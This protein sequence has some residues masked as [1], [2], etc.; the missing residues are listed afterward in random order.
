MGNPYDRDRGHARRDQ[1]RGA[2]F[3]QQGQQVNG[4][5]YNADQINIG[6]SI[7]PDDIAEG[8]KRD[9]ERTLREGE[10]A[11]QIQRER[12]AQ[13]QREQDQR[14]QEERDLKLYGYRHYTRD[15]NRWLQSL[16]PRERWNERRRQSAQTK[17]GKMPWHHHQRILRAGKLPP[18]TSP[19]DPRYVQAKR[20]V[21]CKGDKRE[22]N[23]AIASLVVMLALILIAV[24]DNAIWLAVILGSLMIIGLVSGYRK[25]RASP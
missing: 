21:E 23:Y 6:E 13:I 19:A 22:L 11:A 15:R 14:K 24:L 12:A 8:L 9:R 20:E 10:S 5:Q 25:R 3:N 4:P 2:Y 17:H 1:D 16:P 7:S 18:E